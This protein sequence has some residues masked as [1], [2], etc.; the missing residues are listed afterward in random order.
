MKK[1]QNV[2]LDE[3]LSE[4]EIVRP[5]KVGDTGFH[6]NIEKE[7][8]DNTNFRKVLF[9]SN[10]LQLVVMSLKPGEDIGLE[11]HNSIDQFIRV[12]EGS[13]VST[14]GGKEYNIKDGDAIIVP[15]G[16][17]HNLTAG[18]DGIKLYTVYGPPNHPEGTTQ[19]T[20]PEED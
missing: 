18:K 16:S 20:K 9:T 3:F 13:G 1:W 6:T 14:I 15:K 8:V 4:G 5:K 10:N 17:A 19:K 12:D 7:T 2:K 11:T